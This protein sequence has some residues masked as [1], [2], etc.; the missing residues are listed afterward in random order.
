MA[1]K[2]AII[3]VLGTA[4]IFVIL[5]GVLPV[6]VFAVN[7]SNNSTGNVSNRSNE[8]VN[9]IIVN[10]SAEV[11]IPLFNNNVTDN[12]RAW[13]EEDNSSGD[14][15]PIPDANMPVIYLNDTQKSVASHDSGNDTDA[16]IL[17]DVSNDTARTVSALGCNVYLKIDDDTCFGYDVYVDG[18]YKLTEGEGGTPDGYCAF[19]VSAGTHTIEIRKNGRS[20]SIT[21]NFECGYTYRWVSMPDYWCENGD[22]GDEVK[23]RGIVTGLGP[24]VIGAKEWYVS[25]DKWISGSLPCDEIDV[26]IGIY[27]PMGSYDSDIS[28]GDSVEVYGKVDPW[29]GGKCTVG[30][31][32]ESYYIKKISS[33]LL[34]I[35]VWTDKSEYKIGETVTIY[36][37]T[38]KKCTA[39]LTITKPDGGDV[40][41]GP[42]EIPASTR[43]KSSTAGYP[44]GKRTVVFEAWDGAEYKKAT[45]YFDVVDEEEWEVKFQA[46]VNSTYPE[47]TY[48]ICEVRVDKIISDPD[49]CI[50]E[51][52]IVDIVLEDSPCGS[53]EEVKKGDKIEVFGKRLLVYSF[54]PQISLCGKSSY[55]LKKIDSKTLSISVWTD[56][57]EYKIGE[58]VTIYYQTNK[59]CTAKLTITKPDGGDVV[60]G[61]NEIPASTRSK[62]STAGYPTGKRTVV[63][64]AWDGAEYKKATCYFDVVDE[65]EC[66]VKFRGIVMDIR[67][68]T[69]WVQVDKVISGSEY[70]SGGDYTDIACYTTAGETGPCGHCDIVKKGNGVEVYGKR[71]PIYQIP[72]VISICGKTSYYMRM[73]GKPDLVIEDI[74]WSPSKPK[75]GDTVTINVKTKNKG[76]GDAEGFY[77]C[78]YVDGSYYAREYIS[79]LSAGS[80]TTTSFTWTAERGSHSIKAYAD[81]YDAIDESNEGNNEKSIV[82]EVGKKSVHNIDTGKDFATIQAAIDNSDTGHTITVDA[83]TYT[84]NVDVYKS[85]TIKSTSGNP[86]DTIVEAANSNDSVFNV[87]AD[88]VNISGFTMTGACGVYPNW[89]AGIHLNRHVDHCNITNNLISNNDY[90]IHLDWVS[91]NSITNNSISDNR[92]AIYL[93]SA[94]RDTL[95]NNKVSNNSIGIRLSGTTVDNVIYLNNFI[96]NVISVQFMGYVEANTW[97][98]LEGITYMYKG[99]V[100]TSY[101]GN[102]WSDYKGRYPDANEIDSAGI[103]DTPYSM[104]DSEKDNYPLTKSIENYHIIPGELPVHNINTGKNFSLIQDAID[105]SATL[106]WHTI[107]VERGTYIENVDV[108]KSLTIRSASGNSAD[109]IVQAADSD[110]NVFTVTADNVHID[111]FTIKG[112]SY[113]WC[114]GIWLNSNNCIISNNTFEDNAIGIWT[115]PPSGTDN[116]IRNNNFASSSEKS[117]ST[118]LYIESSGNK[119]YLNNFFIGTMGGGSYFSTL[120]NSPSPITYI[121]NGNTFTS[122]LGNYWDDYSGSDTNAD[123]IGDTPYPIDS[124]RDNYPLMDRFEN[125]VPSGKLP[126]E[127]SAVWLYDIENKNSD[128]VIYNLQKMRIRTVFLSITTDKL[129]VD[130]GYTNK[131]SSF[132][133]KAHDTNPV[134][135]VHA[136]I[137]QSGICIFDIDENEIYTTAKEQ[138]KKIVEYNRQSQHDFDGIHI[139]AEP[140]QVFEYKYTTRS[141]KIATGLIE[142]PICHKKHNLCENWEDNPEFWTHYAGFFKTIDENGKGLF[143]SS[144]EGNFKDKEAYKD[145]LKN[146]LT[147][148]VDAFIPM[149]YWGYFYMEGTKEQL[150]DDVEKWLDI[151]SGESCLMIG[152]GAYGY[153]YNPNNSEKQQWVEI[154]ENQI[155][156]ELEERRDL[157]KV[158]ETISGAWIKHHEFEALADGEIRGVPYRKGDLLWLYESDFTTV[159]NLRSYL[160]ENIYNED[161][162]K[163]VSIFRYQHLLLDF[164]PISI[165]GGYKDYQRLKV[166]FRGSPI[167]VSVLEPLPPGVFTYTLMLKKFMGDEEIARKTT[168]SYE[169]DMDM[170]S[171]APIGEYYI[172]IEGTEIQSDDF[173]II[174][175]PEACVSPEF[176]QTDLSDY[177]SSEYTGQIKGPWWVYPKYKTK[178]SHYDPEVLEYGL[179]RAHDSKS[180][181]EA[182]ARIAGELFVDLN[183]KEGTEAPSN[184]KEII[185]HINNGEKPDA[186]C[187]VFSTTLVSLCRAIG[188]PS[189]KIYGGPRFPSHGWTECF[190]LC[191]N[192]VD[193]QVW[194]VTRD[195][196]FWDADY[197]GYLREIFG[198][199]PPST[200]IDELGKHREEDY[201]PQPAKE[202]S[203][204]LSSP[205]N[206]HAY[207][208]QGNHVGVNEQGEIELEIPNSYYTGPDSEPEEII[209]FG[210]S[211]NIKFKVEALEEGKFNLTITQSTEA[212][213]KKIS[214]NDVPIAETT[215]ATVAVSEANPTYIMEID[216]DGD[217]TTDRKREPEPIGGDDTVPPELAIISPEEGQIYRMRGIPLSVS[218]NEPVSK[219][220]YSLNGAAPVTFTPN[221][222]ITAREGENTLVVYAE[223]LAGNVGS[224]AVSFVVDTTAP[225]VIC[226][227]DVT[228]ELETLE[229]TVVTLEAVATDNCDPNPTIASNELN[230]YPP[231]TTTVTFTATDASG[232]SASCSTNVVVVDTTPPEIT[233]VMVNPTIVS[234]RTPISI[235]ANVFDIAKLS[236]VRAFI[237][238]EGERVTTVFLLDPDGDGVYTGTWRTLPSYTEPGIYNID[239]SATDTGG[240]EALAKAPEVE[241]TL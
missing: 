180:P 98:S 187:K 60:Y 130:A 153:I 167:H 199:S 157:I 142:C 69:P 161:G 208:S 54:P 238:K 198:D 22:H 74:S 71:L 205:A 50:E 12:Y 32:G 144:A 113:L 215:E 7:D 72:M 166:F 218:A 111:G 124:D 14:C 91:D 128:E 70:L 137:L 212:E 2:A 183:F 150:K 79:S 39:K 204:S 159:E 101:L 94:W 44:T 135:Y 203:A 155:L 10:N 230:I 189:R 17:H 138:T 62:S 122:Y 201:K 45:C 228:V 24:Y 33:E 200:V 49:D 68:T 104:T 132:I 34:S 109:T 55:Y 41:Y 40:V 46:T 35:N 96:D 97:N 176:S 86:T 207:D 149:H 202:I 89:K 78:Y 163:G 84:E 110:E 146:S 151:I 158:G 31:N 129:M 65:E 67:G 147:K 27:P 206:L 226:P 211:K 38:N 15:V 160:A 140:H 88:Y 229:G 134:I 81:C 220:S 232:N 105:D 172:K 66:E 4:L 127:A 75:Q 173:Y 93:D 43:S 222:G 126:I 53:Y 108:T 210:Q 131:I 107:I 139:D 145:C 162:Y 171:D 73:I 194:D 123:S 241:I 120:W 197:P 231:G 143:I 191:N 182:I 116:T 56:K 6:S 36:Y 170:P 85:L 164:T 21:K 80:T 30:L 64:E 118:A 82:I 48:F 224:S 179:S 1:K 102:C 58:T 193:W 25:V 37:Q 119:I 13:I 57:S 16:T 213:T 169:F 195:P 52:W 20:T 87:T 141:Y 136:M 214:Y 233:N 11:M 92:W 114:S 51:G 184:I 77:V 192:K 185:Q 19:Y 148:Y 165:E 181:H 47:E 125:Y 90:G 186:N 177:W 235:S 174:F 83:G 239:I 221:T 28:K 219:W 8:L 225:E 168:V 227:A 154:W 234:S 59:K 95:T 209:I 190:H 196:Q 178:T 121:Y 112:A 115:H 63:F 18:V 216:D 26:L 133:E 240:N 76:S 100:F 217:G 236:R 117:P 9:S 61:P 5:M 175:N 23:F 29:G 106:D 237:T 152:I 223:D 99:K 156:Q 42:N 103:W 3:K 188:I